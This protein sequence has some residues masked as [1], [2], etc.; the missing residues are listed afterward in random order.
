LTGGPR[1]D[2]ELGQAWLR[3]V[4]RDETSP[5]VPIAAIA[6]GVIDPYHQVAV[7]NRVVGHGRLSTVLESLRDNELLQ[8]LASI[9]DSCSTNVTT[10]NHP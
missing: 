3:S 7:V 10:A 9:R 5:D 6:K 4:P 1:N 2:V 8:E